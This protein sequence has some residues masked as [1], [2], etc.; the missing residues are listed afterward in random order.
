MQS[1]E[2]NIYTARHSFAHLFASSS[3]GHTQKLTTNNFRRFRFPCQRPILR[4]VAPFLFFFSSQQTLAHLQCRGLICLIITVTELSKNRTQKTGCSVGYISTLLCTDCWSQWI[5]WKKKWFR[6]TVCVWVCVLLALDQSLG[7][8]VYHW[9]HWGALYQ[10]T[11]HPVAH[12][13]PKGQSIT[14]KDAC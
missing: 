2:A 8:A 14:L 13:V 7:I 4:R 9:A 1:A 5:K 3:S 11:I 12:P 6:Q 10:N